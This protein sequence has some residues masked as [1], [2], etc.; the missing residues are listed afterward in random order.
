MTE[1]AAAL[2]SIEPVFVPCRLSVGTN[3]TSSRINQLIPSVILEGVVKLTT[4]IGTHLAAGISLTI[5][6]AHTILEDSLV[7]ESLIGQLNEILLIN[8]IIAGNSTG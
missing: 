2:N 8:Q 7:A 4:K 6:P 1:G 3:I 5:S